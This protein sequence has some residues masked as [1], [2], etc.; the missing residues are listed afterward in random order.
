M[1]AR[2]DKDRMNVLHRIG[3]VIFQQWNEPTSGKICPDVVARQPGYA[4]S[5][6][7]HLAHALAIARAQVA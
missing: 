1:M 2:A 3:V 5:S 7:R 6:K 4:G